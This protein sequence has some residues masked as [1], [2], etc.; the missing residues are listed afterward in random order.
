MRE[1]GTE[2]WPHL[3]QA[4]IR[5]KGETCT[6]SVM[7]VHDGLERT[8]QRRAVQGAP[9]PQRP[10]NVLVSASRRGLHTKL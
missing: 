3:L 9:Q 5:S 2:A 6:E 10:H 4:A 8:L 1:V 7:A